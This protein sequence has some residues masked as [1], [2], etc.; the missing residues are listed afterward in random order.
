M[1]RILGTSTAI[2]VAALTITAAPAHGAEEPTRESFV[3]QA[4]PICARNAVLN[5]RILEDVRE[6]V[7]DDQLRAAGVKFTRV[8]AAF[9]DAIRQLVAIPRPAADDERLLR[10][11]KFLRLVKTRLANIGKALREG[12]EIKAS[13]EQ[14][15]AERSGNSANN[16]GFVFGFRECRMKRSQFR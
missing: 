3:V 6:K 5:K 15:L 8:S 7:N 12:N 9:A 1:K 13:H 4:E 14:I 2:V 10:W 16:V 11:F